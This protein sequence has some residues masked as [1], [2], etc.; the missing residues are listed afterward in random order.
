MIV[1]LER[2][3]LTYCSHLRQALRIS[4][5]CLRAAGKLLLHAF[6]PWWHAETTDALLRE[7]CSAREKR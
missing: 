3:G 5:I 1:H 7:I 4:G 2:Q 6:F